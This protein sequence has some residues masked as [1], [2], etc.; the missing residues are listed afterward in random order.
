MD[1]A[2]LW[3]RRP[4]SR[5]PRGRNTGGQSAEE[6]HE[7]FSERGAATT[8][9][10]GMLAALH[11]P[12]MAP[13]IR[14]LLKPTEQL[15]ERHGRTDG[16]WHHVQHVPFLLLGAEPALGRESFSRQRSL[17]RQS[18]TRQLAG[19]TLP[20]LL[21]LPPASSS[22]SESSRDTCGCAFTSRF[23]LSQLVCSKEEPA[24]F[25]TASRIF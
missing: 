13:Y 4:I 3:R 10:G 18:Q 1:T 7:P 25:A 23:L 14:C 21:H 11:Q 8:A 24:M 20:G 15:S 5:L 16:R 12:V 2:E 6:L 17:L 19:G 22:A 9:R